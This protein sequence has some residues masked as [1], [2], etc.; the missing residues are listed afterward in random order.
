[1]A[2]AGLA[3]QVACLW[4]VTARKAGNVHRYT[5]FEDLTYLDFVLSAAAIG[6]VLA[7][8]AG[9]RVGA[10]VLDCVRATRRV[11][12]S[13]TNLGIVLLLA[14]LATVPDETA[15]RPGLARVL[16]GL[17]VEDARL[18]YEAIRLARPGGMGEVAEQDVRQE[19]TLTLRDVMALAA[20]RDGI[21]RQYG[22]DFAD[23]FDQGVPALLAGLSGTGSLEDAI[24]FAQ[25]RLLARL[26]DSLI[27]RKRGP[28]EA[29]EAGNRAEAVLGQGWPQTR[30]GW[31]ALDELDGW[32]RAEGHQR[33]PGTT[34]D[35]L[36]ASLFVL[37][38]QDTILL[39]SQHPWAAGFDHD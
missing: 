36:T 14:P 37:L 2:D 38:R 39:P 26:P 17:D 25:L 12:A 30:A 20:Q 10:T 34:A 6:P 1:M 27:A 18:V 13:N 31:A 33:N 22:N 3:A 5:D 29:V 32:L 23:V 11:V 8:A 7:N 9:R 28:A 21:A 24:V 16:A 15:L 4:E 35:L 19:P